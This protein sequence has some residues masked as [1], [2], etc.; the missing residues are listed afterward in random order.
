MK[1]HKI[2]VKGFFDDKPCANLEVRQ[3]GYV[4]SFYNKVRSPPYSCKGGSRDEA[5]AALSLRW[6]VN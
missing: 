2:W 4:A 5:H 6:S 1:I 3:N